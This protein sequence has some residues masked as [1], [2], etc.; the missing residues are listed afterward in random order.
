MDEVSLNTEPLLD[1]EM[2]EFEIDG[3]CAMTEFVGQSGVIEGE[4]PL[5][6]AV[7][8][9][10]ETYDDVYYFYNCYAK[11]QGFGVRVSNMWYRKSKERYRGKLSCSSAGFK[12][13][14]EANK[15]RP[16][17][18]TG[19]PAMIK[20]RLMENKRWRVIEVELEH[21]HLIH[22]RGG[23]FY[24]SHRNM[25]LGSKRPLQVDGAEV[26][27]IRLFRTVIVDTNEDGIPSVDES[28]FVSAWEEMMVSHGI[29][30]QKWLQT[31]YVDRKR[32]VP[33]FLKDVFLAGI[34]EDKLSPFEGYLS[35]H[36]PLKEFVTNYV[37]ALQEIYQ[38]ESL[39]DM[40]SRDPNCMLKSRFHFE[41]QLSKLYTSAIFKKFQ[42]E[43]EGMFSCLT[44][45][46]VRIDGAVITHVIQEHRA[47]D[48]VRETR[49][50][51][52]VL[53]MSDAEVVCDC[54][55]FNSKGFLCRHALSV[56]S[57]NGVEEIPP[58]YILP[59][60]RKDIHRSYVLDNGCHGI[61][62]NNPVHR[63]DSLY[64][65]AMRVVE[66][67]Q[68]SHHHYKFT[69]DGLAEIL[70]KVCLERDLPG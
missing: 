7:G 18:R 70:N 66:E 3:D 41:A 32:W 35:K 48:D 31:L 11:E 47:E 12:K 56:L 16:E 67:G 51:E 46:Q 4:N 20:F 64:K 2:E 60:W 59:R 24:K 50:Y 17:T 8:M 45:K 13:K 9:E 53:N 42:C 1:D 10:F 52:V 27:K 39:A 6:P 5:P 58:Q 22:A 15:P 25:T 61:D 29:Q 69:M 65:C 23:K 33:A 54:G 43:I 62:V 30:G 37:Q 28:E 21:N 14:T 55:L 38:R 36:T 68:K 63:Y 34:F 57:Q 19:C 26:Q 49:D 44:T 40:E